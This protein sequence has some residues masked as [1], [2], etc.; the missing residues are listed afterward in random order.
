MGPTPGLWA[1][2]NRPGSVRNHLHD[3]A[4]GD[5][6][7][8][9]R[10][11][12]SAVAPTRHR[13]E[14]CNET[15]HRV[16]TSGETKVRDRSYFAVPKSAVAR[17]SRDPASNFCSTEFVPCHWKY[18]RIYRYALELKRAFLDDIQPGRLNYSALSFHRGR[19]FDSIFQASWRSICS[20]YHVDF[21]SPNYCH[22]IQYSRI[23]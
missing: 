6:R 11:H 10:C 20:A 21:K 3:L 8:S 1:R 23:V 16:L 15:S 14:V 18:T 2:C 5:G 4:V 12:C 19:G 13:H 9:H 7:Y 22:I 17:V